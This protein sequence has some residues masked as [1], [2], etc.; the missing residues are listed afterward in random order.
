MISRVCCRRCKRCSISRVRSRQRKRAKLGVSPYDALL[1]QYEPG[2]SKAA[3]D[4]VFDPFAERLPGLIDE[5]IA[6]QSRRPAPLAPQGP[7]P[8]ALQRAVA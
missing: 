3:I 2:G 1:D 4:R 6:A 5:A 8:I 7:F